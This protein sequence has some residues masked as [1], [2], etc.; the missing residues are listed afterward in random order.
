M[1]HCSRG[2]LAAKK[3]NEFTEVLVV[4]MCARCG[5]PA[6]DGLYDLAGGI[7]SQGK[8]GGIA[9]DLHGAPQGLLR[10]LRHAAHQHHTLLTQDVTD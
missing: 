9:V 7:A 3:V 2:F 6:L 10:P 8:A 5:T 1:Y 4:V